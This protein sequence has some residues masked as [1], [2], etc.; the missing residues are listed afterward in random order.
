MR[1]MGKST[2]YVIR[3][4]PVSSFPKL[5]Q[6]VAKALDGARMPDSA[7]LSRRTGLRTWSRQAW[8]GR[9][10][11]T[12]RCCVRRGE[13]FRCWFFLAARRGRCGVAQAQLLASAE[14][15]ERLQVH[16][17]WE[18]YWD[19]TGASIGRRRNRCTMRRRGWSKRPAR[20]DHDA[21]ADTI[22]GSAHGVS[23]LSQGAW[24]VLAM[25]E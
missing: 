10:R 1:W 4:L 17:R 13:R 25:P 8:S 3:H 18:A 7:D 23:L 2:P 5:P 20:L 16:E 9:D 19:S 14:E 11:L 21:L 15:T 12:G 22:P 24:I 6:A